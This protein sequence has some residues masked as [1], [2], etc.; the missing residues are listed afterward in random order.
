MWFSA[1]PRCKGCAQG[2]SEKRP[3]GGSYRANYAVR[4]LVSGP[5]R[6]CGC[7]ASAKTLPCAANPRI[8]RRFLRIFE[9]RLSRFGARHHIVEPFRSDLNLQAINKLR[10]EPDEAR[11]R[12]LAL[13][14]LCLG[15][16]WNRICAMDKARGRAGH[17]NAVCILTLET[18]GNLQEDARTLE[19]K[20]VLECRKRWRL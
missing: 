20:I 19:S 9:S 17:V 16:E 13:G 12:S 15:S 6:K 7:L 3:I 5:E 4:R 2:V 14:E 11:Q 1:S 10:D 8:G 18:L